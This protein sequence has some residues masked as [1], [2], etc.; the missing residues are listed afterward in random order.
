MNYAIIAS[1]SKGNAVIFNDVI[2]V[3][4]GVS[5]SKLAPYYKSLQLVLLTHI[6]S[7][8]FNKTTIARLA[9][10][11]PMLRFGCSAWLVPD[12]VGCG[13]K[14]QNIDVMRTDITFGYSFGTVESFTLAHDVA[15]CGYRMSLSKESI[16]YATD[17]ATLPDLEILRNCDYYFI[18]A[19]YKDEAELAERMKSKMEAGEFIYEKRVSDYHMS[20]KYVTNWLV[21]NSKPSSRYVFLHEHEREG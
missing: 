17:T 3:D 18:E 19:N 2:L 7:D 4:V 20:E 14:K 10:E 16:V 11:R 15:N 6:H 13:V 8:H 9:K 5:F 12:L 1:G 21:K